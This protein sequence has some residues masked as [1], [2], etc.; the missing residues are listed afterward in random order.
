M[1]PFCAFAR[2][3]LSAFDAAASASRLVV[4]SSSVWIWLLERPIPLLER[5][6]SLL[7]RLVELLLFLS[8]L[9]SVG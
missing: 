7:E 1:L 9:L 4:S 5:P 8:A 3:M 6:V 2:A